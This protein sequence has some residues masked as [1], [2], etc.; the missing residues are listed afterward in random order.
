MSFWHFLWEIVVIFVFVMFLV[1]FFQVIFDLFRS[2]D[3][4]GWAKAGWVILLI[5]L[6]LIGVLI[7]LIARG[8]GM[9]ERAAQGRAE[10]VEQLKAEMGASPTPAEQISQA[11]ALLDSGSISAEEYE[12]LKE[13]ALAA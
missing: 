10:Q 9:A 13:K 5:V 2:R 11:K 12:R 8:H 7:Y 1:I 3:L 6:P 4:S